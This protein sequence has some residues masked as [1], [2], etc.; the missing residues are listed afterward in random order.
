MSNTD[1]I[2]STKP[3]G[4]QSSGLPSDDVLGQLGNLV[5]KIAGTKAEVSA[6]LRLR[7]Q[8]FFEHQRGMTQVKDG[9]DEDRF[10]AYCDHLV[11]IDRQGDD[12]PGGKIVATY[13]LMSQSQ[14]RSAGGFYTASEF[15]VDDLVSRHPT[16]KFLEL[17]RSCVLPEYRSKR[18]IELLWH[19]SWAYVRKHGFDVMFGCA[20]LEGTDIQTHGHA[21]KFLFENAPAD[22]RWEVRALGER[23]D[24]NALPAETPDPKSAIRA[25]PPLIKGYLRL[26]AMFAGE[27]VIDRQFGSVDVLVLLPV[28]RLNPRY[29]NYYGE[30][31]ERHA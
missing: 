24:P 31:A 1:R 19:G 30:N 6:A 10:D 7:H 23:V 17:G 15:D 26:G 3:A 27:A 8:V 18:T 14:A 25:L 28:S 2:E 5:V 22:A 20:S 21:L 29:V 11:V 4:N 13:R 9:V 16:L 12:L